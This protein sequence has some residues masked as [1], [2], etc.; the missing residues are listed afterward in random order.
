MA[1]PIITASADRSVNSLGQARLSDITIGF[2]GHP[3]VIVTASGDTF[4]NSRGVARCTDVVAGCNI[5]VI[6]TC[7]GDHTTN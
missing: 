5:G 6:I 4:C 2:C 3:G 7:S 1:G